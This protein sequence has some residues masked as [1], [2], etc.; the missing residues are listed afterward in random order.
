MTES[1]G[2]IEAVIFDWGGTLA[3][4]A[5]IELEDMWRLAARHL[6]AQQPQKSLGHARWEERELVARL[7]QVE[8]DFWA[9]TATHQRAGTLTDLLRA[10][11]V[12]LGM[13][14]TEAV[15]EE[16]A[17]HYLDAWTPHI[18][19]EPDAG[20]T[21][22]ALRW[23]G[24]KIGLLSNTHWPRTFHEHFLA[25]D[26]LADLIDVRLYTSELHV[27]KPHPEAFRAALDALSVRDPA[28]A[29]FVGDRPF[30][31]IFGA[32]QSGLR[33]VLRTNPEVPS[34]DVTPDAVIDR[35]FELV[36]VVERWQGG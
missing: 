21:L 36:A 9:T 23:R 22:R 17:T 7:A 1:P 35:L 5:T 16:V 24:L 30:D 14:V 4:Y 13:D 29:V 19:H 20:D 31:D 18:R 26:G 32:K 28:R 25:R 10:A 27:M 6:N 8:T 11:A 2:A 34:Y 12:A 15:I 33:A 3:E